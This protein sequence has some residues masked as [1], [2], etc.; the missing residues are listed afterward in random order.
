MFECPPPL[1]AWAISL[2]SPFGWPT[3][4][5]ALQTGTRN[6]I[7][8]AIVDFVQEEG[9]SKIFIGEDDVILEEWDKMAE[10]PFDSTRRL[11]SILVSR[12]RVAPDE[13]GA[14]EEVLDRYTRVYDYSC[15]SSSPPATLAEFN[16]QANA[17]LLASDDQRQILE[18]A[19]RLNEDGL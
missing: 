18:T 16:T 14:V 4:N 11:L 10:V 19:A 1:P 12:S 7:D 13:K 3:L 2:T 17:T 5:S 9:F 8:C 6:L 15:C